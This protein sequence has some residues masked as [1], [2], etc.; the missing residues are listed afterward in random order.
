MPETVERLIEIQQKIIRVKAE[1]DELEAV[2]FTCDSPFLNELYDE[3]GALL[4]TFYEG[5]P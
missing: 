1:I 3:L 4:E 2:G 5:Y